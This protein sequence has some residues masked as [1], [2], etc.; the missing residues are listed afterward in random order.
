MVSLFINERV[1]RRF[2][3]APVQTGLN[4]SNGVAW[5][6]VVSGLFS[7]PA[8]SSRLRLF[9]VIYAMSCH[10]FCMRNVS[11]AMIWL[12]MHFAHPN[13]RWAQPGPNPEG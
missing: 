12:V 4:H 9:A 5:F 2:P 8:A 6:W 11:C 13:P 7:G 1:N 10:V 3:V